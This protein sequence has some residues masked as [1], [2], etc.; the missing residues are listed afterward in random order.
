MKLTV[1]DKQIVEPSKFER[2]LFVSVMGQWISRFAGTIIESFEIHLSNPVGFEEDIISLVEFAASKQVKNLNLDFSIPASREVGVPERLYACLYYKVNRLDTSRLVFNLLFVRTLTICSFLLQMIQDCDDPMD[3][4]GPMKTRHLVMI[5][6]LHANDFMGIRI[7]LNSCPELESLTFD[8]VTIRRVVRP[9]LPLVDPET[10]WLNN[11]TYEW[12]E[13]TLKVVK[14][15]NFCGGSNELQVLSY[16]IRT[17]CVMERVDLY[18]AQGLLNH[19]QKKLVL[20]GA[21]EVQ[22]KFKRASRHLQITLYNA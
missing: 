8:M 2:S 12:V 9:S 1:F 13:K 20:A 17:G 6:N 4:S 22:W 21:E 19:D 15:K 3:V 5:T 14:V 16:L 18:E 7:F 11:K 10:H